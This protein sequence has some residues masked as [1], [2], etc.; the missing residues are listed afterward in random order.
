MFLHSLFENFSFICLDF[1][2]VCNRLEFEFHF[3]K[4]LE[5][6]PL[7]Y[8]LFKDW[9]L[10]GG[11]PGT[12]LRASL[13]SRTRL[14]R[15]QCVR[16]LHDT[17]MVTNHVTWLQCFGCMRVVFISEQGC[18][19]APS[20]LCMWKRF[21]LESSPHRIPTTVVWAC[22]GILWKNQTEQFIF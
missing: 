3:S 7:L 2:L 1:K 4:S 10:R 15:D 16:C 5:Y 14:M 17:V 19:W 21:C 9:L 22:R 6:T 11:V 12:G 18:S 13:C 8:S 20:W